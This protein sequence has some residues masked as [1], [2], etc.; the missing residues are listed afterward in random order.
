MI[1][2]KIGKRFVEKVRDSVSDDENVKRSQDAAGSKS[3]LGDIISSVISMVG[4]TDD[5]PAQSKDGKRGK[6]SGRKPGVSNE[7]R[8]ASVGS[9]VADQ[10]K[11]KK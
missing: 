3:F 8:V 6:E 1:N 2:E 7:G 10:L 4:D 5:S 11:R 9:H